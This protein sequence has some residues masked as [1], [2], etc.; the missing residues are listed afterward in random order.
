[1]GQARELEKYVEVLRVIH[2]VCPDR[3]AMVQRMKRRALKENRLDDADERVIRRR[4][5]VY[6]RETAPVLGFYPKGIVCEVNS[7]GSPAEVLQHVLEVVVP[8]QNDHF[9][10]PLV[11]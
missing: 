7:M 6:D 11:G 10:N 2:L 1:M 3:D 8:V 4:F 5:D 9:L